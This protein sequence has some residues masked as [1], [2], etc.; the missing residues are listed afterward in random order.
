[1]LISIDTQFFICYHSISDPI[2]LFKVFNFNSS[3]LKLL[4]S[5]ACLHLSLYQVSLIHSS[6][7]SSTIQASESHLEI[8]ASIC[9]FLWTQSREGGQTGLCPPGLQ[10]L[11]MCGRLQSKPCAFISFWFSLCC[12]CDSVRGHEVKCNHDAQDTQRQLGPI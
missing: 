4:L 1:M 12:F 5:S 11:Q 3:L 2:A 10:W 8:K 6:S 9:V 7:S